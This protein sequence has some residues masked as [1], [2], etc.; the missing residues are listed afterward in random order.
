MLHLACCSQLTLCAGVG[1]LVLPAGATGHVEFNSKG[2]L[3]A[4]NG[5]YLEITFD[6][7]TG[8]LNEGR[9]LPM[10]TD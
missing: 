6:T 8:E 10:P 7:K 3:I 9:P 1:A 2:D 4:H 5:S